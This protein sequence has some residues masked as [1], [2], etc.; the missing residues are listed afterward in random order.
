MTRRTTRREIE[1]AIADL[2]EATANDRLAE[3]DA[4]E[5][6]C[7]MIETA[8]AIDDE[9]ADQDAQTLH[10]AAWCEYQNRLEA[11]SE[12]RGGWS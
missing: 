6:Y 2:D 11:A 1:N 9:P 7:L 12:P 3:M 8:A 4:D 5:L 10:D